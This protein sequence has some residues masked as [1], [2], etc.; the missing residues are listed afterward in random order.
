MSSS[1]FT[2]GNFS[3]YEMSHGQPR[4]TDTHKVSLAEEKKDIHYSVAWADI[5]QDKQLSAKFQIEYQDTKGGKIK[6]SDHSFI[7]NAGNLFVR[8]KN[9]DSRQEVDGYPVQQLVDS[10]LQVIKKTFH[11]ST[12]TKNVRRQVVVSLV[13]RLDPDEF[14][15]RRGGADSTQLITYT[16][17]TTEFA[18]RTDRRLLMAVPHF[19]DGRSLNVFTEGALQVDGNGNYGKTEIRIPHRGLPIKDKDAPPGLRNEVVL[20]ISVVSPRTSQ[21]TVDAMIEQLFKVF[22]MR[23]GRATPHQIETDYF[24]E[25]KVVRAEGDSA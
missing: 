14:Y 1:Q 25:S 6:L 12:P 16:A 11:V 18:K 17:V 22:D 19:M 7:F 10:H 15:W 3:I 2:P 8:D 21:A 13:L 23:R 24:G 9:L 4:N 20:R 5:F